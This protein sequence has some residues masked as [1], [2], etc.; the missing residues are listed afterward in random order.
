LQPLLAL[1][2]VKRMPESLDFDLG[3]GIERV[4]WQLPRFL[5][6]DPTR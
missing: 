6:R 1:E 2:V 4:D 3:I 5:I